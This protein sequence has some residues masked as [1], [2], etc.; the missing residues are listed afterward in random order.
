VRLEI[1]RVLPNRFF[2]WF[3]SAVERPPFA[4]KCFF[5]FVF[6]LNILPQPVGC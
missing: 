3:G 1:V 2:G 6:F 4:C 5:V